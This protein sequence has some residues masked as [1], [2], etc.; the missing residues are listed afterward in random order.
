MRDLSNAL[1]SFKDSV[2]TWFSNLWNNNLKPA[3]ENVGKSISDFNSAVGNWFSNLWNNNLKPAF[4]DMG[5]S[6]SDF[7]SAVGNWFSNLWNNN[8]KPAFANM[9]K[10]I[11]DFNSSVG[12]WFTSLWTNIQDFFAGIPEFFSN[13]WFNIQSFFISI[14]VPEDGYFDNTMSDIKQR[15]VEKIPYDEYM[16]LFKN[17]EDIDNGDT[18]G[19]DVNIKN[20]KIGNYSLSTPKKWVNFDFVLK[21]KNTWF[22]WVR[23]FTYV[24]FVI[25]NINQFLKLLRGFT[26]SDGSSKSSSNEISGQISLFKGKGV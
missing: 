15:L 3:F 12:N 14:F 23:G 20:Y 18:A 24:F 7:N 21:H 13:F 10:S 9:G 5:Q 8:L 11:S 25:Y 6:I 17:L 4:K 19:L 16:T 1:I 22:A 2:G 26:I